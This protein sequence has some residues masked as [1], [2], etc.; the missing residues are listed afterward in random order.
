MLK[1]NLRRVDSTDVGSMNGGV[2]A[3]PFFLASRSANRV[4]TGSYKG[5]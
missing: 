3:P 1:A 4:A 5:R 2:V